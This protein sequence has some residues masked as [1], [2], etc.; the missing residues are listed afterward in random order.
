MCQV[1]LA[2]VSIE[3][4]VID[5]DVYSFFYGPGHILTLPAY[6]F[7]VFHCCLVASNVLMVKNW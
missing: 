2:N 3:G 1:V 4:R 6:Y 5:S 7:E